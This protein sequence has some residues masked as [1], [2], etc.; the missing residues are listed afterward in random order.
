MSAILVRAMVADDLERMNAIYSQRQVA[1]MTMQVLYTTPA[2]RA[3][4]FALSENQRMLVAEVDGIVVGHA[5]LTLYSRRRAHVGSLG[6][7]VD[8]AYQGQG[9]GTALLAA[10]ID[11][12]DNWYNLRRLE[13]EVY[14]DNE[15]AIRLYR[16]F[17]FVI[18]GAHRAYVYRE[19]TWADAYSMARLRDEPPLVSS[20]PQ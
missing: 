14:I 12:A 16:R 11:L 9:V 18:E 7:S 19:G 4:R 8:Q 2:E 3:A 5:G 20:A 17:G 6:M 15:P 1:A 13:L 10:L